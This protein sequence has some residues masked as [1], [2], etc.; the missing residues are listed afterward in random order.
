M[1]LFSK[2]AIVVYCRTKCTFKP[3]FCAHHY[4]VVTYL[5]LHICYYNFTWFKLLT[6]SLKY[7]CKPYDI[8]SLIRV[9]ST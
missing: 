7:I 4:V 5:Y 3:L 1:M 9:L 6:G 2:I 8:I